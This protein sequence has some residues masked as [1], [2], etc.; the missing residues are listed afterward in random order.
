MEFRKVL[1]APGD[2][3]S[4]RDFP[5]LEAWV[6][7]GQLD[8]PCTEFSGFSDRLMAWMPSMIEHRCS[9]GRRGGFFERLRTGTYLGHILEHVTLELQ[10][11]SGTEV[12]F[13][14]ARETS[15]PGV[16]KVIVEYSEETVGRECLAAVRELCL[17]AVHDRPFDVNGQI[18]RLAELAHEV[19]SWP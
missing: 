3:A 14:K 11:L 4:G 9:I 8:K 15:E 10:S 5:V 19:V 2:R 18:A 1:A 16:Y 6:D 12:G 17:A 13:G 7:L